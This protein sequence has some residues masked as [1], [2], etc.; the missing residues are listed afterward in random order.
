MVVM[1]VEFLDRDCRWLTL[2]STEHS[3]L[4]GL[5]VLFLEQDDLFDEHTGA[6]NG[7][8]TLCIDIR[9]AQILVPNSTEAIEHVEG[10]QL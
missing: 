1:A 10:L 5:F 9:G 6:Q 3:R 8:D 2:S 4:K 7:V